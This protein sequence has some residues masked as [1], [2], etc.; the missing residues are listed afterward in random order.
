MGAALVSLRALTMPRW[1]MTMTEGTLAGWLVGEGAEVHAE[2]EVCEIETTKIANVLEAGGAGVLRRQVARE[3]ETLP[4][5]ALLGVIAPAD[6]P[7]AE[8][9]AFVAAM[10]VKESRAEAEEAPGPVPV[11]TEGRRLMVL[12]MG[13]GEAAPA[14]LL[15][16]FGGGP[17]AWGFVQPDLA[18]DRPVHAVAL[19]GHG[20]SDTDVGAGDLAALSA[21][22]A[23]AIDALGLRDAH[24]VGHSLGG[25]VAV[26]L[27]A[28]R[29]DLARSLALIAPAGFGDAVGP[30]VAD[31][32]AAD[33]RKTVKAA[34][35]QLLADPALVSR[36]MVED[37]LRAMRMDGAAEALKRIADAVFPGGR[38]A[39]DLRDAYAALHLPKLLLWGADDR[40]LP[41]AQGEASGATVLPGTGHLPQLERAADVVRALRAHFAG[42][43]G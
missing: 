22:V 36:A 37:V 19:P 25:A 6:L 13:A 2:T 35:E 8:I 11:G 30:Y 14:V 21:A 23:V 16:G 10:A 40:V 39:I 28:D 3:G 33:R 29:P 12:S 5:G 4:V 41:A 17:D 26:R 9:D 20:G 34:L 43:E 7:E 31:I 38:Q 1:G 15:H 42:A 27:A 32:L 18:T 24:I